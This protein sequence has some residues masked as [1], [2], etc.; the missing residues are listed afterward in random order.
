[1]KT[2]DPSARKSRGNQNSKDAFDAVCKTLP[3]A[4]ER[5]L[6]EIRISRSKGR[7]LDEIAQRFNTS[8]N[9]L[10]GRVYELFKAG[11]ITITGKRPTRLGRNASVYV[12]K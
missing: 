6:R 3:Q 1:M 7:T 10:S 5:V 4:Q 2:K 11:L 12:L 8:P 9:V